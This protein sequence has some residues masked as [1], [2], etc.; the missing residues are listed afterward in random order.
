MVR[1]GDPWAY[2]KVV[3]YRIDQDHA[4]VHELEMLSEEAQISVEF[5]QQTLDLGPLDFNYE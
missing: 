2:E 4:L 5:G 3:T 1:I